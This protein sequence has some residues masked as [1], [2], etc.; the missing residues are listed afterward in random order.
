MEMAMVLSSSISKLKESQGKL[1]KDMIVQLAWLGVIMSFAVMWVLPAT[2][3]GPTRPMSRAEI[4]DRMDE[5]ARKYVE[6]H[7]KEIPY[8]LYKLAREFKKLK[9][10]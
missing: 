2:F 7:D 6:T 8:E 5:F 9:K 4:E 1:P 3:G 10:Q